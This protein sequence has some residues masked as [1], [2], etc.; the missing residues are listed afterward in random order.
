MRTRTIWRF[1]GSFMSTTTSSAWYFPEGEGVL[2]PTDTGLVGWSIVDFRSL[3]N[4][5]RLQF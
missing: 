3:L 4:S 1:A 5:R 2:L